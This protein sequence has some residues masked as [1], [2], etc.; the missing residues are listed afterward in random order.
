MRSSV[1]ACARMPR[2]A[3]GLA[4]LLQPEARGRTVEHPEQRKMLV[5]ARSLGQLDDRRGLLEHLPAAVEHEVV[6][7]RDLAPVIVTAFCSLSSES[8]SEPHQGTALEAWFLPN[9]RPVRARCRS[10]RPEVTRSAT[11]TSR[12][13][14]RRSSYGKTADARLHASRAPSSPTTSAV[15]LQS[16]SACSGRVSRK[17]TASS[18]RVTAT[19]P[20]RDHRRRCVIAPV[21]SR[22]ARGS[23]PTPS[24]IGCDEQL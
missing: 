1:D 14:Q 5:L 11:R 8:Y 7:G 10:P 9:M 4:H 24:V 23:R 18:S 19:N 3:L 2:A 20:H 13:V 16:R 15:D 17:R 21:S 22:V 6:V 12:W